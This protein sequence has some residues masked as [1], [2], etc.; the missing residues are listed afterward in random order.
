MKNGNMYKCM[1]NGGMK[2]S[3]KRLYLWPHGITKRQKLQYPSVQ[4]QFSSTQIFGGS[5]ECEI[6]TGHEVL[7][8]H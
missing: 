8:F 1:Q 3:F 4:R 6:R 5:F 2:N 7:I